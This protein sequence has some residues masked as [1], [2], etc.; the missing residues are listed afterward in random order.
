MLLQVRGS[1]CRIG[2][3]GAWGL[4]TA[5]NQMKQKRDNALK[6]ATWVKLG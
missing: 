1:G 5:A 3:R 4:G 2:V 6:S